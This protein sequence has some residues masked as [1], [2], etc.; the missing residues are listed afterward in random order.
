MLLLRLLH[1]ITIAYIMV[2]LFGDVE[3][4]KKVA[5][6]SD[7]WKTLAHFEFAKANI[8]AMVGI[9]LLSMC[10]VTIV[11]MMSWKDN[12]FYKD[13]KGFPSMS[14]MKLCLGVKTTQSIV[15]VI[16]QLVFLV[17]YNDINDPMM[18]TQAKILFGLNIFTSMMTVVVSLVMLFM[19][20]M[21]L[22]QQ[23][24]QSAIM[25]LGHIYDNNDRGSTY[26][27]PLHDRNENIDLRTE[28]NE[29]KEKVDG[30]CESE[31]TALE[32]ENASLKEQIEKLK[33]DK[34]AD[35]LNTL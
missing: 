20:Q 34:D 25:E 30:L 18:S 22:K 31:N 33:A 14:M 35:A 19:K 6:D 29:L 10:D 16:C 32:D 15:S 27:N 12:D 13:S 11:Q 4:T 9:T 24:R 5:A 1:P 8:P 23:K 28:N 17:S 26:D 7:K 21:L 2:C 3:M